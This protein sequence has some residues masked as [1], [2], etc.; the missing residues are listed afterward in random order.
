MKKKVGISISKYLKLAAKNRCANQMV[1]AILS[2]PTVVIKQPGLHAVL[3]VPHI[4]TY[5]YIYT[6]IY[7]YIYIYIYTYIYIYIYI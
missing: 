2:A 4:Y 7:I 5:E 1:R 6:Y 3:S